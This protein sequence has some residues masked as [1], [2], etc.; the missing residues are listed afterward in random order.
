MIDKLAHFNPF[1][2]HPLD[3]KNE[4]DIE[5][6]FEESLRRLLPNTSIEQ[7]VSRFVSQ[8]EGLMLYAHF[9]IKHVEDH[10]ST[11]TPSNLSDVFP[12]GITSV[13]EQYFDRLQ[14][15]LG[16]GKECFF[17]FLSSL[18]AARSPLPATMASRILGLCYDIED[19]WSQFQKMSASISRLLPIHDGYIN[20]FHKSIVDWLCL[21]ELYGQHKFTVK[22]T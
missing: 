2:L 15:D 9:V 4:K 18:A 11:L 20:V 3:E 21:P 6:F 13:Y 16:V 17:D 14:K 8:A 22:I 19:G 1:V 5:L 10:K 7:N 12:R